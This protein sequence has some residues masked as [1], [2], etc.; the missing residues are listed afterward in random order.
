MS[1]L[2]LTPPEYSNTS[3]SWTR[4]PPSTY[5][6]R[7]TMRCRGGGRF[8]EISVFQSYLRPLPLS[9]QPERATLKLKAVDFVL[10]MP[11]MITRKLN[12]GGGGNPNSYQQIDS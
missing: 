4:G 12:G 3:L 8:Q 2:V 7:H 11:V 1:Q 5:I 10:E 6:L 9:S